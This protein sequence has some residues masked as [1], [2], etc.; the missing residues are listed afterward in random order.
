M[1]ALPD[2]LADPLIHHQEMDRIE[3]SVSKL[4]SYLHNRVSADAEAE[5]YNLKHFIK[6]IPEKEAFSIQNIL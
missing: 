6:H 1:A 5:I 2:I 3:E 4:H